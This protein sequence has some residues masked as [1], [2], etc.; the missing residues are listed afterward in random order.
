MTAP[1]DQRD[2]LVGFQSSAAARPLSECIR[3]ALDAYF[4]VLD[5]HETAGL[6]QLVIREV[7]RPLL[8]AVLAHTNQNQS[9]AAQMLGMSRGTLRKK[10]REHDISL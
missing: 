7:E 10:L 3:D 8:E 9:L 5:G 1:K 4:A 2:D 6:Y